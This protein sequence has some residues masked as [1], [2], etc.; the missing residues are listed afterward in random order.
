VVSALVA[1]APMRLEIGPG[2]RPRLPIAGTH[3]LDISVPAIERLGAGGGIA[4]AGRITELPYADGSFDLVAAFD[5][6]EHVENDRQVFA[7]L[8]RVLKA[9]GVLLFSVPLHPAEW[10]QFDE[11]VGH[12]RRYRPAELQALLAAN[13]W[14]VEKSAVF[15]MQANNPFLLHYTVRALTEYRAAAI[16][17]YNWLFFPLGML[18]QQKLKWVD[19]LP[20]LAGIHEILLVCRRG[21]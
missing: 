1:S 12:A 18:L 13:G 5:V 17:C 10:N 14:V 2:L 16:R 4:R 8:N 3:F 19:G 7:E 11:V 9:D 21:K 6:I 20:D 15:G